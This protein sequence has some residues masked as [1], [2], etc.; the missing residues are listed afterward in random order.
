VSG[1]QYK[2]LADMP[3]DTRIGVIG[4]YTMNT[5]KEVAFAVDNLPGKADRYM[6]KLLKRFPELEEVERFPWPNDKVTMIKIRRKQPSA[7]HGAQ[8]S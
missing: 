2:D 6:R 7:F 4:K 1:P 3:E 5:D 8:T